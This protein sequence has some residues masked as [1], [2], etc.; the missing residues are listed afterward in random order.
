[1][2]NQIKI[3]DDVL[4]NSSNQRMTVVDIQ[5]NIA[6]CTWLHGGKQERGQFPITALIKTDPLALYPQ[7]IEKGPSIVDQMR[8]HV[9]P[10]NR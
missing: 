7:V 10:G 2:E 4:L 6:F 9:F 8:G 1:M 3:N 5:D